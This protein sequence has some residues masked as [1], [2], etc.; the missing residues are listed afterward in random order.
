MH[1]CY[2]TYDYT[3]YDIFTYTYRPTTIRDISFISEC[4]G[5]AYYARDPLDIAIFDTENCCTVTLGSYKIINDGGSM[6]TGRL[7]ELLLF[8]VRLFRVAA[9]AKF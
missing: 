3:N 2:S 5:L 9:S 6:P 7:R 1:A 4:K 8:I